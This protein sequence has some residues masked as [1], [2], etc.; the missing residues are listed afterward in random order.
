MTVWVRDQ[1]D[2]EMESKR[3]GIIDFAPGMSDNIINGLSGQQPTWLSI[4]LRAVPQFARIFQIPQFFSCDN[5]KL[6]F[7]TKPNL[8]KGF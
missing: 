3:N 1:Q 7:D 4:I 8:T 6:L 5:Q 2:T